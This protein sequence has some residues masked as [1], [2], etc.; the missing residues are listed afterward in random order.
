[1][2]Y[3]AQ[4]AASHAALATVQRRFRPNAAANTA[5]IVC[6]TSAETSGDFVIHF[7]DFASGSVSNWSRSQRISGMFGGLY[8]LRM[9]DHC[10]AV[11]PLGVVCVRQ[12][13]GKIVQNSA[14]PFQIASCMGVNP[15]G[16]RRLASAPSCRRRF[17]ASTLFVSAAK[18]SKVPL[19]DQDTNAF[20]SCFP[21]SM[22]PNMSSQ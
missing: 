8:D 5:C 3:T 1:M 4:H 16:A 19:R 20:T 13:A 22:W 15:E 10:S 21:A 17:P 14:C 12:Y 6:L 2:T 18:C 9:H 11:C 7:N